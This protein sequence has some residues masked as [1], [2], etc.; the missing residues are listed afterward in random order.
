MADV[1]NFGLIGVGS[2]VQFGK[3]GSKI[4]LDAGTFKFKAANGT[5]DVA[6]TAAGVTSSAAISAA[7]G[8]STTAGGV[9]ATAGDLTATDGNLVLTNTAATITLGTDTVLSRAA[10]GVFQFNGTKG[11]V[12]PLGTTAQRPTGINGLIR[13]NT[14][15]E[16]ATVLEY[17]A[18]NQWFTIATGGNTGELSTEL[19]EIRDSLGTVVNNTT[20][21]W[22]DAALTSNLYKNGSTAAPNLT[23][24]LNNLATNIAGKDTLDEIFPSLTEGN[25][26]YSDANNEWAQAAPG[27]TSGVQAYD[28]GLAALAAKTSTGV[29]VQTGDDTYQSASF[30]ATGGL[31][32][33]DLSATTGV[34]SVG[35]T[36]NLAALNTMAGEGIAVRKTDGTWYNRSLVQPAAG[37]T[38]SN[39]DGVDG[40]P[41][42]ALANDLAALEGLTTTGF[43]VRTGDGTAK[44][45]E[46][47]GTDTRIVVT[48]GNGVAS[49]PTIDLAEVTQGST[50][51]FV[52]VT[53]DGYGRVTGNTAVT[54]GDITALV[55]NTY[56]NIDGD[57]MT[58]DLSFGGTHKVTG[59]AAPTAG[60]DAANKTYVDNAVAGLTW[61][62]AVNV[63]SATNV[64]LT[65]TDLIIDADDVQ[66]GYRI[67]LIG[68]TTATENGIYVA[69]VSGSNYTLA[70][71]SDA[72]TY[73]ELIGA[74]VFVMEGTQY[75]STGWTQSNHYLT[76]F[77]GQA[78]VQ[79]SGGGTYS[80]SGAI[81]V[82]GT[83]ISL[84][85]GNGLSQAGGQLTVNLAAAT[86][87]QFNSGALTLVLASAGGLEQSGS[88][89]KISAA[90]VT[91]AMLANS[92]LTT[93][94]DTG[95]GSISLG[96]TL[97]IEGTSAQGI[98]TSVTGGTF[99]VTASNASSSQKGVATFNT[100]SFTTTAGDVTIKAG[101]VTN[102][103]LVNSSFSLAADS[104]SGSVALGGTLTVSS[105][106]SAITATADGA[107]I[108]LQLETVDVAHG[109]TGQTT[110]GANQVM[111]G[112][113]T[114]AVQTSSALSFS[115]T[116]LTVGATT[117]NGGGT[118]TTITSTAT[119]GD[120][121]LMPNGTG[122]VVVGPVG[123]G[124][125]QSDSGT[126]LT[127]RGNTTLTL[128]SGTGST[129]MVLA[130]GTTAKVSV[131]GPTAADYATGLAAND[132]TNKQYVDT[133]IAS[134]A[135]AGAVK[136]FQATVPLDADGTTDIGTPMPAGATV[137][138]VKVQVNV[139]DSGAELSVGKT[140]STAAYMTAAENDAQTNGLYMAECFVT[141]SGAVQLIGT[142]GSSS[143]SGTGSAQVIVTYQVA[144]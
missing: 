46:I 132:L 94:A 12:L 11:T 87:L 13:A 62:A 84:D 54:T 80:G 110:L 64:P 129:S 33:S 82:V 9:T 97:N 142:V 53:L 74:T 20:G 19:Q 99:T 38:I 3:A 52:K 126:A 18:N 78:W 7:T 57:T 127:I 30:A 41:T 113:G 56:V 34:I 24:A 59:L 65:G 16:A 101:G 89:L 81:D 43:I 100:A 92:T 8:I 116:T 66:N 105:A 106:D 6:V 136:S 35:T 109:G 115:G 69:T 138:S 32:V 58:G 139:A 85:S 77:A 79:F 140:G 112:N 45:G 123:A 63:L 121:V 141:E 83:T 50:G 37:L 2:N 102:T 4:V 23:V 104:G 103:Q 119:N 17:F 96:G 68:Q 120:I 71:S 51:T 47:T 98:I 42:F 70:R 93:D 86:A 73:Q 39:A 117:I 21:V 26:I 14:D 44:T 134:G 124:L 122:S 55:D 36:G 28:A 133:A 88:G 10:A 90:G 125:I 95:T 60:G 22:N 91:N 114:S 131:S 49:N 72:D 76:S 48:N 107:G 130:T 75:A 25:V 128:E 29:M 67:L 108:T 31:T 40:N 27:A 15:A 118:D 111:L 135:S 5:T 1:K 143:G 144:Q 61:K 137:L